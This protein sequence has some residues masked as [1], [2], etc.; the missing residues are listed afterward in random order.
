MKTLEANNTN[1]N[2]R[3][4]PRSGAFTLIEL[5]VV[6]AIIAILAAMLLPALARSKEKAKG[7][8]CLNNLKQLT[9][10]WYAYNTDNGALPA[11]LANFTYS[12]T[13][14]CTGVLDWDQGEGTGSLGETAP[15][16]INTNYITKA[17]LG[18]YVAK[19]FNIFK[20][21]SDNRACAVGP[22]VRSISMNNFMGM[23][24]W[25]STTWFTGGNDVNYRV[26]LKETDLTIPGPANLWV[27]VDE[28]PDG[29]NDGMIAMNMPPS[30]SFPQAT[31]WDDVPA[32]YHN[33][34]CGF[35]FADGHGE[36]HKWLDSQTKA[37]IKNST[38]ASVWNVGD[39][40]TTG[41]LTTSPHDSPWIIQRT[42]APQ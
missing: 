12:Y 21:P 19:N 18:S 36:I 25:A 2:P 33:G 14:W 10:A 24:D 3:R 28:H 15:P 38:T 8:M 9:I 1:S 32:S 29:I 22:R 39:G 42:S 16:N 34:A 23:T 17:L 4:R 41:T 27:F 6:I 7:I 26:Y 30:T 11:N 35:G 20:C 13:T 37:P 40:K 5:L 31:Q